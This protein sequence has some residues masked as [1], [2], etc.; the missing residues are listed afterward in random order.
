[1]AVLTGDRSANGHIFEDE[2]SERRDE[3]ST[4]CLSDRQTALSEQRADKRYELYIP[5]CTPDGRYKKVFRFILHSTN[6]T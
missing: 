3:D 2:S 6:D 5:E 4:D 1:M